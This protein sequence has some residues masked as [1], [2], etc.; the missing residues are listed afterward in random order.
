MIFSML[1]CILL[2]FNSCVSNSGF[3]FEI[4]VC[5]GWFFLLKI[6]YIIIGLVC[7]C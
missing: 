5:I 4:V 7:G 3:R 1:D 6:F 2:R